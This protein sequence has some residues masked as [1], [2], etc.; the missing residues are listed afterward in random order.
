VIISSR[1]EDSAV[2]RRLGSAPVADR[3]SGA[4][5][6]PLFERLHEQRSAGTGAIPP[7]QREAGSAAVDGLPGG[8]RVE[9]ID[10][11]RTLT[12]DPGGFSDELKPLAVHIYKV[13]R[14]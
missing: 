1:W 11:G 12:A 2:V 4:H 8:A 10:E 5:H 6:G 9:V 13:K 3:Q 14:P 7:D